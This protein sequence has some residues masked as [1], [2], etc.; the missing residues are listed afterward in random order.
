MGVSVR[1]LEWP[2]Q[3]PKTVTPSPATKAA[4]KTAI[5]RIPSCAKAGWAGAGVCKHW[6]GRPPRRAGRDG[7]DPGRQCRDVDPRGSGC[8]TAPAPDDDADDLMAAQPSRHRCIARRG[9]RCAMRPRNEMSGCRCR[10]RDRRRIVARSNLASRLARDLVCHD[11]H[12]ALAKSLEYVNFCSIRWAALLR[13]SVN[14]R[15]GW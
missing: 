12:F 13:G 7:R 1:S 9:A 10:A 15:H 14:S 4:A 11:P 8:Q 3:R 2:R 6:S 5:R